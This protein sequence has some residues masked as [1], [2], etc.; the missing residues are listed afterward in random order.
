M[1]DGD[2]NDAL[3]EITIPQ[4]VQGRQSS[5]VAGVDSARRAASMQ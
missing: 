5:V 2:I 4:L 1:I 3:E